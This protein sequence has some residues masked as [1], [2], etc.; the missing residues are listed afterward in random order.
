MLHTKFITKVNSKINIKVNTKVA[1]AALL[2]ALL[3]SEGLQ[4][5]AYVRG[6]S[7][8]DD[9]SIAYKANLAATSDAEKT[10]A[11]KAVDQI[12]RLGGKHVVLLPKARMEG[13]FSNVIIDETPETYKASR[14]KNYATLIQY[15][16]NQGM[17]VGIRPIFFVYCKTSAGAMSF[18]CD[19]KNPDGTKTRWWHGNIEPS[20]PYLWFE[21]FQEYIKTYLTIAKLSKVEEF[22]IASELYSMTVG[23]E[24]RWLKY[25]HG[26]PC[27][28]NRVLQFA[29]TYLPKA[30]VM[31]DLTFTDD[32]ALPGD[33]GSLGGELERWRYRLVDLAP[34]TPY[35]GETCTG[36]SSQ[37][38][39]PQIWKAFVNLWNGLDEMGVDMYRSLAEKNDVL[40][41]DIT[42]LTAHLRKKSDMY[43]DQLNNTMLA[44]ELVTG[45][46]KSVIFKEVGYKSKDRGFM[47]AEEYDSPSTVPNLVHQAAAYEAYLQSFWKPGWEWYNGVIFWD[48]SVNPNRR[49]PSDAGFTPLDKKPTEK[50]IQSYFIGQ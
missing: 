46:H 34:T 5:S 12:K 6:F 25:P 43:A 13:P 32:S 39:G 38:S 1:L 8:T 50:V 31:Y 29:R 33:S 41:A 23:I 45:K 21:S 26:F 2:P 9:T 17:T 4:A 47:N 7:L 18:P 20:D 27:E 16:H 40:A 48:I 15:I 19:M 30:R 49:G 10:D 11:Q 14:A 44:I 37:L 24:D 36:N 22:T 35:E 3:L 42:G 28:W